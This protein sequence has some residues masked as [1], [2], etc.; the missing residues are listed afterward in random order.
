MVTGP[1]I[2]RT[3]KTQTSQTT[4]QPLFVPAG[5]PSGTER[6]EVEL[7]ID[8]SRNAV[9]KLVWAGEQSSELASQGACP[10]LAVRKWTWKHSSFEGLASHTKVGN[11]LAVRTGQDGLN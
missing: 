2:H 5:S 1:S 9:A 3:L 11:G 6:V 10:Q 4:K 7:E 8:A